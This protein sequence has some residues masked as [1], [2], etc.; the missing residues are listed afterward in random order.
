MSLEA[1]QQSAKTIV[2][3]MYD[4]ET[5]MRS[6]DDKKTK[7]TRDYLLKICDNMKRLIQEE[8]KNV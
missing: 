3:S 5:A 4:Y 7:Q 2:E 8:K 6:K 1:V